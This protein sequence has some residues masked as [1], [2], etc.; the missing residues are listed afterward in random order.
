MNPFHLSYQLED[1][2]VF[3]FQ[4]TPEG[5]LILADEA[6]N[7]ATFVE[8]EQVV[9]L[10]EEWMEGDPVSD[11]DSL[12]II[13]ELEKVVQN[14]VGEGNSDFLSLTYVSLYFNMPKLYEVYLM[15]AEALNFI[16]EKSL[17]KKN[18]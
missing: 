1:G 11:E 10:D 15:R 2:S 5:D 9:S 16:L 18:R 7:K 17:N 14:M 3:R 4:Y 6:F 8:G 13:D 12:V